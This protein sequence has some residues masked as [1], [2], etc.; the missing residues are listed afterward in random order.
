MDVPY[1]ALLVLIWI[2]KLSNLALRLI[3]IINNF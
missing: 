2:K 1:F 3:I